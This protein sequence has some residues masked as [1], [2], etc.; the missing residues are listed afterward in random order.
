M[1]NT[2]SEVPIQEVVVR[3]EDAEVVMK[4]EDAEVVLKNSEDAEVVMKSEDA[5]PK[6]EVTELVNNQ[7]R[8]CVKLPSMRLKFGVLKGSPTHRRLIARGIIPVEGSGWSAPTSEKGR[9]RFEERTQSRVF[10]RRVLKQFE[11]LSDDA[12]AHLAQWYATWV[13]K[14]DRKDVLLRA[15]RLRQGIDGLKTMKCATVNG[16]PKLVPGWVPAEPGVPVI[17]AKESD[18]W[19]RFVAE[20]LVTEVVTGVVTGVVTD[21]VAECVRSE[22]NAECVRSEA[23]GEVVAEVV[24][25][26]IG[27]NHD[28]ITVVVSNDVT[29]GTIVAHLLHPC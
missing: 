6:Q 24:D 25:H 23:V 14:W 15:I 21:L 19:K 28:D 8:T 7:G 22:A 3:S 26:N 11:G 20:C 4:S 1:A 2:V 13:G 9:W 12:R 17:L 16:V 10:V 29:V 5:Q 27:S 18:E